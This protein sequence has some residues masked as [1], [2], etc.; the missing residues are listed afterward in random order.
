MSIFLLLLIPVLLALAGLVFS[1]GRINP[2]EFG[3][4]L[5]AVIL[6]VLV[7]YGIALH[8]RT[9]DTEIWNGVVARKDYVQASCCHPYCCQTCESCSTDS[10]GNRTCSS[11]CCMT[12]YEHRHDDEWNA[13]S[14]NNE[15]I[16]H[17]GCNPPYQG[18][19]PRWTEIKV[20]E[21]T[22]VEHPYTNYI[23]GNPDTLVR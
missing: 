1:K 11:Y 19:P 21:P 23:K 20:G 14:S 2:V 22:A 6:I 12:C 7:P 18:A 15:S 8:G 3:V 9:S 4:S 10:K 13:T 16:Y 5:G 17:N